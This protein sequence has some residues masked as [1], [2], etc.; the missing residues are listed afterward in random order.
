MSHVGRLLTGMIICLS[1]G[2]ACERMPLAEDDLTAALSAVEGHNWPLAERL[3]ERSLRH[4]TDADRR[5][6][7]WNTLLTVINAISPEPHATLDYLEAMREEFADD[8][9][10]SKVIL[11]R[12]GL[13]AEQLHLFER[14]AEIWNIYVGLGWL[15]AEDMVHGYRRLAAMQFRQRRFDAME[16]TLQ[17]CLSM[18]LPENDKIMCMYDLA[19]QKSARESWQEAADLGQQVMEGLDGNKDGLLRGQIHF[20]LGDALEQL[21]RSEEALQQFELARE[22]YPN[23]AVVENR[24]A[25]LRTKKKK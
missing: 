11:E 1:L 5:W 25:H 12:M 24:I 10:R 21:G 6:E 22:A 2:A 18:P 3:L 4:E 16:E 13:L 7:I 19:E 14:A 23:P 17:Q 8:D 20:L 15:S 9:Q